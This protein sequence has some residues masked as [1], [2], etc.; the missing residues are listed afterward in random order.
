MCIVLSS[1]VSEHCATFRLKSDLWILSWRRRLKTS[2]SETSPPLPL[3]RYG[4]RKLSPNLNNFV[5]SPIVFGFR[6]LECINLSRN[7]FTF[8]KSI[9]SLFARLGLHSS[10]NIW[11]RYKSYEISIES[12]SFILYYYY[13]IAFLKINEIMIALEK[14]SPNI[15][16]CT[17]Y[18]VCAKYE[19]TS[20]AEV[21]YLNP[22]SSWS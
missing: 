22:N 21:W 9:T 7:V 11:E 1:A 17:K 16:V 6:H 18:E 14:K 15:T 20:K 8:V 13:F 3:K 5:K 19:R 4:L 2:F 12:Y 10:C